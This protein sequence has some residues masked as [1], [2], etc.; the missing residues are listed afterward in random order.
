[1]QYFSYYTSPVGKLLLISDGEALTGLYFE[2]KKSIPENAN[3]NNEP[4][5]EAF[6]TAKAWLDIYF[7]GD[8][9]DFTPPLKLI[10]TEF[11]ISVWEIVAAIP[12]GKTISYGE[13]AEK[14]AVQRGIK[15]MSAQAVGNAVGKNPIGIIIP[16]HRV[17]GS[18]GMLVGYSAGLDKKEKLLKTEKII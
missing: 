1:M 14:I 18:N 7:N 4:A 13:I 3:T 5:N 11:Q 8:I 16:C 15:K 6:N 10:G 2:D 9:P 12:Y 17:I